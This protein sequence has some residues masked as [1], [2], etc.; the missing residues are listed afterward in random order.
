MFRASGFPRSPWFDDEGPSAEIDGLK[1]WWFWN[2][3]MQ[4][5]LACKHTKLSHCQQQQQQ[6]Q[7]D[8]ELAYGSSSSS[9]T[10]YAAVSVTVALALEVAALLHS[11]DDLH[12]TNIGVAQF[13]F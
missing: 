3:Y 12:N 13:E 1:T 8:D 5:S 7:G 6:V 11:I 2:Q 4:I 9:T 10:E